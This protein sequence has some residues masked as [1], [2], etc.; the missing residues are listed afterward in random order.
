MKS[1]FISKVSSTVLP[2]PLKFRGRINN[3]GRSSSSGPN[4]RASIYPVTTA[5]RYSWNAVFY[6]LLVLWHFCS[7]ALLQIFVSEFAVSE[8]QLRF[9]AVVPV[10]PSPQ[11]F[12]NQRKMNKSSS[13]AT[14]CSQSCRQTP[15]PPHSK[16]QNCSVA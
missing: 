13:E 8:P 12:K 5:F 2:Q 14:I 9:C 15:E 11:R 1:C 4:L 10:N 7:S 3:S 16:E 6:L